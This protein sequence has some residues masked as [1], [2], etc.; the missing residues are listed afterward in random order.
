MNLPI[1]ML[2]IATTVFW[3]ILVGFIASA[4]YS[5]KDLNFGVGEPQFTGS[6]DHDLVLTLPLFIDNRGYYSL[7]SFNLTTVFS[8]R[9]GNEISRGSTFLAVIPQGKNTTILHHVAL[10]MDSIAQRASQYLF[11]DSAFTCAVTAGV[12]FAEILPTTLSTNVTFPWGAP[13]Y[14][15]QL[16]QPQFNTANVSSVKGKV[17]LSFD[18]HAAFDVTGNIRVKIY[19]TQDT[20]LAEGQTDINVPKRAGYRGDL[21][22]SV[23][24]TSTLSTASLRGHFEV[25]F[26]TPMFEYGPLVIL[27]G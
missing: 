10:G 8:D 20:L 15:F 17:P 19:D 2:G 25:Y 12:N 13:L 3:I 14:N 16:G 26:S 11:E 22:F 27:F 21:A 9:D 24:A 5:L 18:N 6:S 1:R 23:P 4:G 7:E